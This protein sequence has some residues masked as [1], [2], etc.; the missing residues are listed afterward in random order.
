MIDIHPFSSPHQQGVIDLILSIQQQE[1][2]IPVSLND[3]PDLTCSPIL[4]PSLT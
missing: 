1:F 2:E 3:Q 4:G